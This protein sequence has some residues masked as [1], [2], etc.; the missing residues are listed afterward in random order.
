MTIQTLISPVDSRQDIYM[1]KRVQEEFLDK[2]DAELVEKGEESGMEENREVK[3]VEVFN[4]IPSKLGNG[5]YGG[6]Y[7]AK[8]SLVESMISKTNPVDKMTTSTH[9]ERIQIAQDMKLGIN[10]DSYVDLPYNEKLR[11]SNIRSQLYS[12]N[13]KEITKRALGTGQWPC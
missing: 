5:K 13:I 3:H 12:T 8:K 4:M 1:K 10:M 7:R 9:V 11:M 6:D 2:D